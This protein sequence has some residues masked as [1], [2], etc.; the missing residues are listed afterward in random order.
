MNPCFDS[1]FF[2]AGYDVRDYYSVAPRYGTNEDLRQLCESVHKCGM[3]LLLDLVPG[4][5]A[6]DHPWFLES[7]KDEQNTSTDRYIWRV[8]GPRCQYYQ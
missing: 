1:S 6:I 8:G 5:T 2:D 7:C 4:H 3:H